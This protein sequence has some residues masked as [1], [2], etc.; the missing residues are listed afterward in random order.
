MEDR[1]LEEVSVVDVQPG[2][3]MREG[4]GSRQEGHVFVE[5]RRAR[6]G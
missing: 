4:R 5:V 6:S 1:G 3:A 2:D